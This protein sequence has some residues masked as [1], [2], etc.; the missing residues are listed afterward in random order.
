M[1]GPIFMNTNITRTSWMCCRNDVVVVT[2]IAMTLSCNKYLFPNKISLRL[3]F[4]AIIPSVT[5]TLIRNI[6]FN[7]S[8]GINILQ[9]VA[10]RKMNQDTSKPLSELYINFIGIFES[11]QTP[12]T[13]QKLKYVSS[14]NNARKQSV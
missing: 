11:N 13:V 7:S 4:A 6:F 10:K 1:L 8:K 9:T 2:I 3:F 14:Q 5:K 12:K